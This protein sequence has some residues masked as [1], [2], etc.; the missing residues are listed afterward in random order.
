MKAFAPRPRQ[1]GALFAINGRVTGIEL[2]DSDATFRRFMEKLVRSY[3]L[4]AIEETDPEA[5][6][7]AAEAVRRF[8]DAMKSAA[9]QRFPALAEGEDLR[10]ESLP[11]AGEKEGR[12]G[13]GVGVVGGALYAENRIVHLCAFA[14]EE[15]AHRPIGRGGSIDFE[16]PAFLRRPRRT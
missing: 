9:F 16:I 11:A 1:A 13:P 5:E 2:F 4:D 7:P 14:L 10:F 8:L 3:V 15:P 12:A 6:P